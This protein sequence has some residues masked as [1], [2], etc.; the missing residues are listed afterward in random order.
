M[1]IFFALAAVVGIGVAVLSIAMIRKWIMIRRSSNPVFIKLQDGRFNK[2]VQKRIEDP[3]E[4]L[5]MVETGMVARDAGPEEWAYFEAEQNAAQGLGSERGWN[6]AL[7]GAAVAE[8][9]RNMASFQEYANYSAWAETNEAAWSLVDSIDE[10]VYQGFSS[11][12]RTPV[13]NMSDLRSVIAERDYQI[14]ADGFFSLL[15]GHTAEWQVQ[16]NMM[17]VGVDVAMPLDPNQPGYD[18]MA[19]GNLLNIKLYEDASSAAAKH[20]A[21]YPDISIVVPA[22]AVNI[23]EDAINFYPH[24]GLDLSEV[25][26]AGGKFTIVDHGLSGQE[27]S[28]NV[29]TVLDIA[30]DESLSFAADGALELDPFEASGFDLVDGIPLMTIAISS[31]REGKLLLRGDTELA[32]AGGN[33]A[34]DAVTRG[35]GGLAGA[36]AGALIGTALGP[37]GTL[38]GGLVGGVGGALA[39]G[40]AGNMIRNQPLIAASEAYQQAREDYTVSEDCYSNY[41]QD[42][43]AMAFS[44]EEERLANKGALIG[45]DYQRAI[46]QLQAAVRRARRVSKNDATTVLGQLHGFCHERLLALEAEYKRLPL[47]ARL[48]I[49][50]DTTGA[51]KVY[52][53]SEFEFDQWTRQ[54]DTLLTLWSDDPQDTARFFDLVLAVTNDENFAVNHIDGVQRVRASGIANVEKHYKIL[55][56]RLAHERKASGEALKNTA[57]SI[58]DYVNKEMASYV[59]ALERTTTQLERELAR[60]GRKA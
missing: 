53:Q 3:T 5:D 58:R 50:T 24:E 49:S 13:E 16:E 37:V 7:T 12:A 4:L 28:D 11:F 52:R 57:E 14:D 60:Q 32:R 31:F 38:V 23:P 26:Q 1:A 44:E 21:N 15:K 42:T 55:T 2:L 18:M 33:I 54:V 40:I 9:L 22:D 45:K 8:P 39:G 46:L 17:G 34:I 35:G 51:R 48:G 36:K 41:A 56:A 43:W 47:L 27:V 10:K 30:Q 25:L 59:E 29:R 20:F 6:L 19:D